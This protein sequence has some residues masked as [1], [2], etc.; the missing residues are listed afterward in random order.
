MIA[1]DF[2]DFVQDS[3]EELY[4]EFYE[5]VL[6]ATVDEVEMAEE[7]AAVFSATHPF[8]QFVQ[9]QCLDQRE[10]RWTMPSRVPPEYG[11]IPKRVR[12]RW[13]YDMATHLNNA[14]LGD[15]WWK[16]GQWLHVWYGGVPFLI[17]HATHNLQAATGKRSNKGFKA[18]EVYLRRGW[19]VR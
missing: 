17:H 16:D 11:R 7:E 4:E 6:G 3:Y 9:D 18:T 13:L 5:G 12:G 2:G 14:A 10:T 1:I 15:G 8:K 19:S